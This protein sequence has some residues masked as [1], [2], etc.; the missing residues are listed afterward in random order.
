MSVASKTAKSA[1]GAKRYVARAAKRAPGVATGALTA[2]AAGRSMSFVG[3][4]VVMLALVVLYVLL[5]K[6]AALTQLM[7]DLAKWVARFA[8]PAQPLI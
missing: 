1:R 6:T 4:L 8:D 3:V 5:T 7:S 2:A